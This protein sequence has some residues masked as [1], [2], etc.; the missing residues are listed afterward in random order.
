MALPRVVPEMAM[1][2]WSCL[3]A[4]SR[5]FFARQRLRVGSDL[6]GGFCTRCYGGL[7][8]GVGGRGWTGGEKDRFGVAT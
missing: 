6:R 7:D 4:K 1:S 2:A 3:G 8:C 5:W